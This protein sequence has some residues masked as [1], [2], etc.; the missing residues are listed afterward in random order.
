MA[1]EFKHTRQAWK[2]MKIESKKG[3]D[4][5]VESRSH[6]LPMALKEDQ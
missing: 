1:Q 2:C 3:R 5:P 4:A 6:P